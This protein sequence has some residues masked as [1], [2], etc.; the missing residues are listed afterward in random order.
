MQN[1]S[2]KVPAWLI[3]LVG[4]LLATLSCNLVSL[5]RFGRDELPPVP[6]S[7]QS[8]DQLVSNLEDALAT[9]SSGG[10]VTLVL[11]EQQLTSLAALEM[12]QSG[13]NDIQDLQIYLRDGLVKITGQVNESGLSLRAAIDVKI[14][15]DE[16]GRPY[17]EVVSARVGPF[18][19][20][21][22]M[23]NQLTDQLDGYLLAQISQSGKQ[24]VV[25]QITIDDGK[26][27]VVGSLQ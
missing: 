3:L 10:V 21:E 15:I 12:Q 17:S 8:A 22:D 26:M 9:A 24:L 14:N 2:K 1:S 16:K 7:S 20:P 18:P 4:L 25:K 6:V 19:I 5:A 27:T 11:T 23:L 13:S